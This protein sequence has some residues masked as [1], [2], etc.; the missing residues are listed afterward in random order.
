MG[1]H[2]QGLRITA[3]LTAPTAG[4][5]AAG[6]AFG[7]AA[8]VGVG[9]IAP[10]PGHAASPE[11]PKLSAAWGA[12]ARGARV[13]LRLSLTVPAAAPVV[14]DV[15]I[16]LPAGVDLVTTRLGDQV[17][18]LPPE[19]VAA[20][21]VGR[22][23]GSQPCPRNSLL[24][25]GDA[26]AVLRTNEFE[27][28]IHGAGRLALYNGVEDHGR[29]G[30]AVAV[31][32][33]RPIVSALYYTGYLSL[34]PAPYGLRLRIRMPEPQQPPFGASI[35]LRRLT[36]NV[37]SPEIVYSAKRRGRAVY[38]RPGG[39]EIPRRCVR[40]RGLPFRAEIRF[41]DGTRRVATTRTP[42]R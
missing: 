26:T 29:P 31:D 2:D 10:T 24:G 23:G 34:A 9:T 17:C 22:T 42:C 38:Y 18:R 7:T 4:R 33:D 35:T 19:A 13:P 32:T 12:G 14:E 3:L 41:A 28:P 8:L 36:L 37:G 11:R 5:W 6:A 21:V 1:R 30:I 15:R 25:V 16:F 39:F 27:P 40:T 20:V